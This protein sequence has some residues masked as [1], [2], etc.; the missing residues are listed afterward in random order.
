MLKLPLLIVSALLYASAADAATMVEFKGNS[1]GSLATGTASVTLAADGGSIFGTLTNT[2]PFD[3]QITAFG[4]NIGLGNINGFAGAPITDPGDAAFKFEDGAV[5]NV[6]QYNSVALDFGYLTG[7]NFTGGFPVH[8]LDN[9]QTLNFLI[10]GPFGGLSE[11]AIATGLYVRFQ[12]VGPNGN[13][14]DVAGGI[15]GNGDIAVVP[16]PGSM[17]LLGTG[18][19]YLARRRLRRGEP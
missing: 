12:R 15:A 11:T 9:W 7:N 5:G 2:S 3:A 4:F 16:E 17:L 6:A 19:A 18:L 10:T 13:G 14:S 8:G 1:T